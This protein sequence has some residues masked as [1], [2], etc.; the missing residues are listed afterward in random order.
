VTSSESLRSRL[1]TW[2]AIFGGL[3]QVA[4]YLIKHP[5]QECA[6]FRDLRCLE[7]ASEVVLKGRTTDGVRPREKL[8]ALL[9]QH[10]VDDTS[11][12]L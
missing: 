8:R 11:I 1:G 6:R 10:G 5:V 9:G 12:S 2:G 7:V 3:R 4:T